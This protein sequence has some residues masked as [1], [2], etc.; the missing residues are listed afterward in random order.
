[1]PKRKGN[2]VEP[3]KKK[4]RNNDDSISPPLII[5]E[6]KD[7]LDEKVNVIEKT[8][9][10]DQHIEL[11]L[12]KNDFEIKW[13]DMCI[14]SDKVMD[15][16]VSFMKLKPNFG[17]T[18]ID[19]IL[20]MYNQI[21]ESIQ[22]AVSC[23]TILYS[24][25]KAIMMRV[26]FDN[27]GKRKRTKFDKKLMGEL[28]KIFCGG[29]NKT[30]DKVFNRLYKQKGTIDASEVNM[31]DKNADIF[32]ALSRKLGISPKVLIYEYLKKRFE[33]DDSKIASNKANKIIGK[34]SFLSKYI[35]VDNDRTQDS[36]AKYSNPELKEY[37]KN[38]NFDASWELTNLDELKKDIKDQFEVELFEKEIIFMVNG[39]LNDCV[40]GINK[41]IPWKN[42]YLK[43][44]KQA[45]MDK[46][47]DVIY[48]VFH[49]NFGKGGIFFEKL[50][51]GKFRGIIKFINE[52]YQLNGTPNEYKIITESDIIKRSQLQQL[53]AIEQY[54]MDNPNDKHSSDIS[55]LT[56]L[57]WKGSL[58]PDI[59]LNKAINING[60]KYIWFD[61]KNFIIT[62]YDHLKYKRIMSTNK[63]YLSEY[64]F[65]CF[66]SPGMITKNILNKDGINIID[67]G[68][69]S[70]NFC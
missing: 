25:H 61:A 45:L 12:K 67:G 23:S 4:Q 36:E 43:I 1:M 11:N 44:M 18:N 29:T 60:N 33:N 20:F 35:K 57:N 69:F 55:I 63:K 15:K 21:P 13:N 48:N 3:L 53:K 9:K 52:L 65:G 42:F 28:V 10:L 50:I 38:T 17:Q 54:K 68:Y 31:N 14:I 34:L 6:I 2:F 7:N 27:Y 46:K 39:L 8:I 26:S 37:L 22:N 49:R 62:N 51:I 59:L 19:Q 58:T 5:K 70:F 16:I 66:I 24:L 41:D 40:Y 56:K 64:G 47:Y 32:G 30:V